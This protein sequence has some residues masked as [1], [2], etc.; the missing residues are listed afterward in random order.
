MSFLK[1]E[2]EGNY[3]TKEIS[4]RAIY[5]HDADFKLRTKLATREEPNNLEGSTVAIGGEYALSSQWQA[6]A[7]TLIKLDLE[8]TRYRQENSSNSR[9]G[10]GNSDLNFLQ[11]IASLA[12]EQDLFTWWILGLEYSHYSYT[13]NSTANILSSGRRSRATSTFDGTSGFPESS[14]A[15]YFVFYPSLWLDVETRY[16][17][18]ISDTYPDSESYDLSVGLN[19]NQHWSFSVLASRFKSDRD[20]DSYGL[21][22][23][24]TF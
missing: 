24:Y 11:T 9:R 18:T 23:T 20:S 4:F 1:T 3:D 5:R 2:E 14:H 17:K 6:Q 7:L 16:T 10:S 21:G 8:F 13:D 12:I 22:A 19:V 15:V